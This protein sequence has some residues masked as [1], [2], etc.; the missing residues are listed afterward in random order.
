MCFGP[1]L[2]SLLPEFPAGDW[3]DG[4]VAKNASDGQ[5]HFDHVRVTQFPGVQNTWHVTR[6]DYL[7]LSIGRE[8]RTRIYEATSSS[9]FGDQTIVAKFARFPWEIGYIE[10]DTT[11]TNGLLLERI[12]GARHGGPEDVELYAGV[13]SRS[14]ALGIRHGDTNRFN[15]LVCGETAVLIDFDTARKC[16]D[17]DLLRQELD[18]LP[19]RLLYVSGRGGGGLL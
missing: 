8:L 10:G 16:D 2:I 11:A 9:V 7:D 17:G 4:L 6:V 1:S 13:L 12:T 5:P 3:N 19:A 15:F 14:H 18:D